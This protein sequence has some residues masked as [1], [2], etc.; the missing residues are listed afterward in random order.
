[1]KLQQ[2]NRD[3]A[4]KTLEKEPALRSAVNQMVL[5]T[6]EARELKEQYDEKT[7]KLSKPC[8]QVE[9]STIGLTECGVYAV[10]HMSC[11]H[12]DKLYPTSCHS[13]VVTC[14][15]HHCDKLY[16]TSCHSCVVT[17]TCHHFCSD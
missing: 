4:E 5:L 17:C 8:H 14:T 10:T 12:C 13:C 6:T 7:Q 16:P 9:G 1:M 11:H 2:E 15:C 3:A